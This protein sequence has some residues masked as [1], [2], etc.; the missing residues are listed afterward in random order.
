MKFIAPHVQ[1]I[2]CCSSIRESVVC[3][4]VDIA[5]NE[6]GIQVA[7]RPSTPLSIL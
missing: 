3:G 1:L 2:L 4:S 7:A 5:T 6:A